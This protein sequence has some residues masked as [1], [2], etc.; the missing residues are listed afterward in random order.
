MGKLN[1]TLNNA[2]SCHTFCPDLNLTTCNLSLILSPSKTRE[3]L[4]LWLWI[5]CL[6]FNNNASKP[7]IDCK[8]VGWLVYNDLD[9]IW[10]EV[11][12]KFEI[13]SWDVPGW[14]KYNYRKPQSELPVSRLRLEPGISWLW[15]AH[16]SLWYSWLWK[17]GMRCTQRDG[18]NICYAR[19]QVITVVLLKILW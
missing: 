11:M 17:T 18:S 13:Q 1:C 3:K 9:K 5:Y 16:T 8:I 2:N 14:T 4:Y 12:S 7:T 10:K 15:S 6:C 19:F